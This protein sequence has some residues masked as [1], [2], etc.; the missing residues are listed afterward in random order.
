MISI[1][2]DLLNSHRLIDCLLPDWYWCVDDWKTIPSIYCTFLSYIN[3][4]I[5]CQLP[6]INIVLC[7]PGY[8]HNHRVPKRPPIA[9]SM[10]PTW[11]PSGADGTQVGPMLAPRTLLSGSVHLEK[12]NYWLLRIFSCSMYCIYHCI[13]LYSTDINVYIYVIAFVSLFQLYYH[14]IFNHS[15][16]TYSVCALS[17]NDKIK[18]FNQIVFMHKKTQLHTIGRRD[19]ITYPVDPRL[20]KKDRLSKSGDH[21]INFNPSMDT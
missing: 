3:I 18:L 16:S 15:I 9:R 11:G 20:W 21:F 12:R 5:S 1:W 2:I 7:E 10:G 8:Y 13:T 6:G 14:D 19:I 17:G 4:V